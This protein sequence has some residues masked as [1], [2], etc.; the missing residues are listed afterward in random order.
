MS[1]EPE[2]I[3][4]VEADLCPFCGSRGREIKILSRS[5]TFEYTCGVREPT[6]RRSP[7]C[8]ETQLTSLRTALEE[9]TIQRDAARRDVAV[10]KTELHRISGKP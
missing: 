5:E 2:D 1:A 7:K 10:L 8:Y 6:R 4:T 3:T 9:M